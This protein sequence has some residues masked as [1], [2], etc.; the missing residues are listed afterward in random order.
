MPALENDR[1]SLT[2]AQA[3]I[4]LDIPILDRVNNNDLT[5]N[6]TSTL[7]HQSPCPPPP[8]SSPECG[9]ERG[10]SRTLRAGSP[11]GRKPL[12]TQKHHVEPASASHLGEP[13][14]TLAPEDP[15]ANMA[16]Y[17]E[18]P[19][20]Y[21]D[22][23]SMIQIYH[24]DLLSDDDDATRVDASSPTRSLFSDSDTI[25]GDPNKHSPGRTSKWDA[26]EQQATSHQN[27]WSFFPKPS[28][29]DTTRPSVLHSP[30]RDYPVARGPP[31]PPRRNISYPI[32]T[33]STV[34]PLINPVLP[35]PSAGRTRS[36]PSS[37]AYEPSRASPVPPALEEK[38]G[39]FPEDDE[40]EKKGR[41]RRFGKS[42]TRLRRVFSC[43]SQDGR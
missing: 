12:P 35:D 25:L 10:R 43:G 2:A 16:I 26:A 19:L 5:Y 22:Y 11:R 36:W 20:P 27:S 7:Q 24:Q 40:E 21:D 38:S 39:W 18:Q 31:Q 17:P 41:R 1:T 33:T 3:C 32:T 4:D 28:L 8:P 9:Q 6:W 14:R 23:Y 13:N 30:P 29:R 37:T 42:F 15:V 34:N